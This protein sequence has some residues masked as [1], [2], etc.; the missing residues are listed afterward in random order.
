M[1][2]INRSMDIWKTSISSLLS[3]DKLLFPSFSIFS[4]LL[5][6]SI[7]YFISQIIME[8]CSSSSYSFHFRHLS[9]NGIMKEAISS[10]NMT[11]PIDFS[12]YNIIQ[13]CPLLSYTFMKLFIS[14][15]FNELQLCIFN[16]GNSKHKLL[17]LMYVIKAVV[18][19]V[20]NIYFILGNIP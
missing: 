15:F 11:N 12:T 2:L 4:F 3:I 17:L 14:Y 5:Q 10:Q 9:F 8:L 6:L 7:S 16:L 19:Y 18:Q 13:K 1:L 20:L